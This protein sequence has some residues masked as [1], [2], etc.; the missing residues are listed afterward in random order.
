[1]QPAEIVQRLAAIGVSQP[2][3]AAEAGLDVSTVW[4]TL[5]HRSRPL[6]DTQRALEA[7][8]VRL[9]KRRDRELRAQLEQLQ[10]RLAAA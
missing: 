6:L 9:E 2:M 1:M 10:K 5:N 8:L 4:R 7:A 3:L